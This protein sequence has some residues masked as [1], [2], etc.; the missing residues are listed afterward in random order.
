MPFWFT[1]AHSRKWP[2]V[3]DEAAFVVHGALG[4]IHLHAQAP[5]VG[6]SLM[7]TS[8]PAAMP[9]F[10][11][12]A[13]MS[14]KFATFSAMRKTAP[15]LA[16]LIFPWLMMLS[17]GGGPLNSHAPPLFAARFAPWKRPVRRP[18]HA[19][20]AEKKTRRIHQHHDAVGLQVSPDLRRVRVVDAVPNDGVADGC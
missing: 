7:S 16:T 15:P 10:P 13:T 11:P 2:S 12:G 6:P 1:I 4:Q 17:A 18:A 20:P 5:P 19:N 8:C 3:G 9:M 14:P